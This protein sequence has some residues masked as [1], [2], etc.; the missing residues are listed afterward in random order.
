MSRPRPIAGMKRWQY[1]VR[2]DGFHL[3][4]AA[5]PDNYPIICYDSDR[6]A[7]RHDQ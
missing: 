1:S 2:D 6:G 7:W 4:F 5:N 3:A